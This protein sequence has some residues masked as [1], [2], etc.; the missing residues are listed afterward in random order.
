MAAARIDNLLIPVSVAIAVI[1]GASGI[2][3]C[4]AKIQTRTE[5]I[6]DQIVTCRQSQVDHERRL[7]E[8]ER[9]WERIDVR[10]GQIADMLKL[11]VSQTVSP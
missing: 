3:W 7:Q 2:V 8:L 4:A 11:R 5:W 10:L 6:A 1:G 9:R